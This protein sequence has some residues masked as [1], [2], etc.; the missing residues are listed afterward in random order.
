LPVESVKSE[1]VPTSV[2]TYS[3]GRAEGSSQE[4]AA[5]RPVRL[6]QLPHRT[7]ASNSKET[8]FIIVIWFFPV[9]QWN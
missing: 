2:E 9:S 8:G 6:P 7:A 5:V 1:C 4:V 3:E